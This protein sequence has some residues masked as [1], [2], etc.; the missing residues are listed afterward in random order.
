MI[1]FP[2]QEAR[3]KLVDL[4]AANAPT[5]AI[6]R[7]AETAVDLHLRTDTLQMPRM[8]QAAYDAVHEALADKACVNELVGLLDLE[9]PE[10]PKG[11]MR[12]FMRTRLNSTGLNDISQSYFDRTQSPRVMEFIDSL[13]ESPVPVQTLTGL[14]LDHARANRDA[15]DPARYHKDAALETLSVLH[16]YVVER[17]LASQIDSGVKAHDICLAMEADGHEPSKNWIKVL[18]SLITGWRYLDSQGWSAFDDV[19]QVDSYAAVCSLME[20][21]EEN[22]QGYA[23]ALSGAFYRDLGGQNFIKDDAHLRD[24]MLALDR[25][26]L[27]SESRV[28]AVF[29]SADTL[30]VA[31][32]ILD[33]VMYIASTGNLYLFSRKLH[34][35]RNCKQSFVE[36]LNQ[37]SN[38]SKERHSDWSGERSPAGVAAAV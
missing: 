3:E 2:Y 19:N 16:E 5:D 38:D 30:G 14:W 12:V 20:G 35:Q 28:D 8:D 17:D 31:P 24:S 36:F 13:P 29:R 27:K 11:I 34:N 25:S 6:R 15:S 9:A 32:R 10:T 33:K 1:V 21:I 4:V 23:K 7:Y 26:L 22:V 18:M 37:Q